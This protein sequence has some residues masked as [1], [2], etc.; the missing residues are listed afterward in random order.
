MIRSSISGSAA[1]SKA[2]MNIF[3]TV[4]VPV[5]YWILM[6]GVSTSV[7]AA[8]EGEGDLTAAAE[9]VVNAHGRQVEA[10]QYGGL[11]RYAADG[12]HSWCWYM[13]RYSSILH[14]FYDTMV[15]PDWARASQGTQEFDFA[16]NRWSFV[17]EW[18][19]ALLESYEIH[20]GTSAT[21]H[22]RPGIH[23]WRRE[24]VPYPSDK[25]DSAYGTELVAHDIVRT[26][27]ELKMRRS[28]WLGVSQ[29]DFTWTVVDKYTISWEWPEPDFTGFFLRPLALGIVYTPYGSQQEEPELCRWEDHLA[30]GPFIPTDSVQGESTTYKRN[31]AYWDTD[32]LLPDNP[33]P[34]LDEIVRVVFVD[35]ETMMAALRAGKLD[36]KSSNSTL[37][38]RD[39]DVLRRVNPGIRLRPANNVNQWIAVRLDTNSPWSDDRV[40][41]AAM[42]AIDH[43][44]IVEDIYRGNGVAYN[45]GSQPA[46]A[47]L[48]ISFDD[49]EEE[50]PDLAKLWGFHPDAAR[51][52][53]AESGFSDGFSSTLLVHPDHMEFAELFADAMAR[54][55][56]EISITPASWIES[57]NFEIA[58]VHGT[59]LS[60]DYMWRCCWNPQ[61]N[62]FPI[63]GDNLGYEHIAALWNEFR[64]QTDLDAGARIWREMAIETLEVLPFLPMPTQLT[65]NAWQPWVI[66]Y[67]GENVAWRPQFAKYAAINAERKYEM[68]GRGPN[69]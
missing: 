59:T 60:P 63:I 52:L 38:W 23:F 68:S 10:P 39:A 29:S 22:V 67:G 37:S 34:Y 48:Y 47:P 50:R 13:A 14:P 57:P 5:S 56:I 64:I 49:L 15:Q 35:Q 41:Q 44:G 17:F 66:N 51:Q 21:L 9:M 20:D 46:D 28:N 61:R 45:W 32:P 55:K 8:A 65:Y 30:T 4:C 11:A 62:S 16:A 31:P 40:R 25:L 42:M 1:E 19:P 33:L 27:N 7:F 58:T 12:G 3:G 24:D 43:S 18:V 36:L 6:F 53:L 54:V 2:R 26:I 69:E